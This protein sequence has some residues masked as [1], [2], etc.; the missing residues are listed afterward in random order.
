MRHRITQTFQIKSICIDKALD[1][2]SSSILRIQ[3]FFNLLQF[4]MNFCEKTPR[5]PILVK[6]PFPTRLDTSQFPNRAS[7]RYKEF[8][9]IKVS[10]N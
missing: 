5:A 7:D 8:T 9:S 1:N 6:H 3:L 4:F 2:I 10:F